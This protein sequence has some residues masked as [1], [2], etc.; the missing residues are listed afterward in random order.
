MGK[1]LFWV[2]VG[3]VELTYLKNNNDIYSSRI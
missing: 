3:M 1:R 2:V